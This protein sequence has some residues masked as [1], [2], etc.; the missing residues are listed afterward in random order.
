M[1]VKPEKLKNLILYLCD[2]PKVTSLGLTK[3]YKLI[4]FSDV[5]HLREFGTSITG[6]EYIKYEH[7]PVPSRGEK[8]IKSLKRDKALKSETVS[9]R[10]KTR[11]KFTKLNEVDL[12]IFSESEIDA[13][14]EVCSKFGKRTAKFLSELSH[15]EP[16]WAC[17]KMQDKLDPELMLPLLLVGPNFEIFLKSPLR[18]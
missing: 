6:S 15:D 14:E 16:S 2:H 3:L 18:S 5:T 4:Y 7:G 13:I 17:A 9:A 10:G 8:L 12:K 11:Y 1:P